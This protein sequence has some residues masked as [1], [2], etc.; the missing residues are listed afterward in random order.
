[1]T[2]SSSLRL[3]CAG[4]LAA[5]FVLLSAGSL[6]AEPAAT[7]P[8]DS[9]LVEGMSAPV[10]VDGTV[11]F[12]VRGVSAFPA[13]KRAQV[14]ADRIVE[15]ADDPAFTKE[16]LRI[17]EQAHMS[18]VMAGNK[19]VMG[20]TDADARLDGIDRQ[21]LARGVVFG[22]GEAV[23]AWRQDRSPA[24]LQRNALVA[25][26][27]TF[28]LAIAL[29]GGAWLYRRLRELLEK[30]LHRRIHDVE[31]RGFRIFG[32]EQIWGLLTGVLALF[33]AVTVLAALHLYLSSV[34]G[35]F[36][37]T[38]GL[39]GG[40]VALVLDPLRTIGLGFLGTLP[41]L[42]FLVLLYFI[43]RYALKVVRLYFR[44]ISE[45]RVV[46]AEFDR[47]WAWPTYR[48]VRL[49]LIAFV[50]IVA[51]PYIPGSGSEAFK[52]IT[53][54]IGVMFSLGSSSVIGNMIAGYTMTYRRVFK[55]GDR[56]KI[57]EHVGDVEQVRIL[58]TYLRT[59]KN[60]V[61]AIPNST[62]L[63]GEVVNYSTLAQKEGLIL[64]TTV[65]IGYETP[66]RQV[67]GMLLEAA[68]RTPGLLREP[69]PF[70]R[71]QSLGDFCVTYEI[72]AYCADPQVMFALYSELHRNILDVFN[73]YGVQIMVPAYEGDPERPKLVPPEKWYAPPA[74]PPE[75]PN[76]E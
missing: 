6:A 43:T 8:D 49:V 70:V 63:N 38:R 31:L 1:M 57:G 3:A 22:I 17:E 34:L 60:E 62:I 69:P 10:V 15:L 56:V 71:Q 37:W 33:W 26:G 7:V 65:G 61:V 74:R 2:F 46:L 54:F 58:V 52:G 44:N 47:E 76:A 28:A 29:W 14:I 30:R 42:V 40:L 24:T 20:V 51:Y 39:A 25:L 18:V 4:L 32:G 13:E 19:L 41:N 73:E 48:L 53:L 11:L 59:P 9:A 64:H 16:A 45:G 50:L 68:A 12:R 55:T 75:S 21:T 23:D 66:W 67:E 5:F 35:L 72:N 36:P 27:A